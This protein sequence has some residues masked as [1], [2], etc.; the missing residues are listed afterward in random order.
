MAG[1]SIAL[2][3][4]GHPEESARTFGARL[5]GTGEGPFLRTG[6][7]GFL[8]GGELFVT[9]RLKDLVVLRGRNHYPQDLEWTVERSHPAIRA[10]C[11]AA[12]AYEEGG[13]E[14]L[15]I[16]AE[17]EPG[18]IDVDAVFAAVRG[19]IA[20]EHEALVGWLALI[21]P[22]TIPKTSSG[23]I[24]RSATR[25]RLLAGRLSLLGERRA[26]AAAADPDGARRGDLPADGGPVS[27]A[28]S[29]RYL[30]RSGRAL[31]APRGPVE[32]RIA[33]IFRQAL[34][35]DAVGATDPFSELGGDSILGGEVVSRIEAAFGVDVGL[36]AAFASFTVEALARRVEDQLAAP[37][38]ANGAAPAR[39][40]GGAVL[41]EDDR[42][43]Y[44]RLEAADVDGA[45]AV[46]VEAFPREPMGRASGIGPE[47]F[48]P[49]ARF[50]C[51]KAAVEGLSLVVVDRRT[52]A[53]V[54]CGLCEDY[55]E[56]LA[57]DPP[58]M[59]PKMD[60]IGAVLGALDEAYTGGRTID[61]GAILHLNLAAVRRDHEA[62]LLAPRLVELGLDLGKA[63]GFRRAVG[64][65]A[66]AAL[67]DLFVRRYGFQEVA[68]VDYA[69]FVHRGERVFASIES[70][71]G[72]RM[73]ERGLD[74]WRS[75]D[76]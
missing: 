41:L 45:V 23:K 1:P 51:E 42:F 14:R 4:W 15:G 24:Q 32:E 47:D 72:T 9:G 67:Q 65:I 21:A 44:K 11:T 33:G 50:F 28:R 27:G 64:H 22:R 10:G 69:T 56:A 39:V 43:T 3:Y 30:R 62:R 63:R 5:P 18:D 66:A 55:A 54:A 74:D 29:E 61:P 16:V 20:E 7:L 48:A 58:P 34:R 49:F 46:L 37:G 8:S 70:P 75:P 25:E 12:F 2:G 26:A 52:G 40:A 17:V 31:V 6:D 57:G 13:G 76:P 38:R 36:G 73:L 60:A 35:V 59:S 53:V 68:R 71:A 19:A